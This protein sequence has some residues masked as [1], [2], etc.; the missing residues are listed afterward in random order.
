LDFFLLIK[1]ISNNFQAQ[2][3]ISAG[4]F[5]RCARTTPPTAG[6]SFRRIAGSAPSFSPELWRA[7]CIHPLFHLPTKSIKMW[8]ITCNRL[9]KQLKIPVKMM[10]I[11]P[12][13]L[14]CFIF[15]RLFSL[16]FCWLYY[17]LFFFV[18]RDSSR[19]PNSPKKN[20]WKYRTFELKWWI[21][22]RKCI[23]F[24]IFDSI[25][26]ILCWFSLFLFALLSDCFF[27]V[28]ESSSCPNPPDKIFEL[29]T[30][31]S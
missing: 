10:K 22:P 15:D 26:L 1:F 16:F 23:L 30:V 3:R 20:Q 31:D 27:V 6:A 2:R 11:N 8:K 5:A 12:I 28:R 7:N 9:K 4:R 19:F 17:R 14:F 24:S 18:V 29:L 13:K 21:N 25:S